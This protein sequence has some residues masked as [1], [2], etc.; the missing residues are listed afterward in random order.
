MMRLFAL[1]QKYS[2][3]PKDYARSLGVKIGVGTRISDYRHWPSEPYLIEIGNNCAVTNEVK[4]FTHGGGR[5]FR[6]EIPDYD[7]F[8]K[9]S[10][11]NNVYIGS[12]SMIMAGV[13]IED[14]VMVAAGSVVTKSVPSGMVVGGNP[15]KI[16][17]TIEEYKQRN[18]GF[19]TH[20]KSMNLHEKRLYLESL[21]NERFIH[22]PYMK[23]DK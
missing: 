11:G 5:V 3:T 22:K 15:A 7:C 4:F 19:N 23:I 20:S 12:R 10:I 16:I 8:G 9:I 6:N 21:P 14:N 17:C 1:L 18:V 2:M 13:T